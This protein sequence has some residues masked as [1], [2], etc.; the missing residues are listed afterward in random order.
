[1]KSVQKYTETFNWSDNFI[2]PFEDQCIQVNA[3]C[4]WSAST[5]QCFSWCSE[6]FLL[7]FPTKN[8]E[9]DACR[10]NYFIHCMWIFGWLVAVCKPFYVK[11]ESDWF[12]INQIGDNCHTWSMMSVCYSIYYV[13]GSRQLK[14]IK[15][16][17][18]TKHDMS[19]TYKTPIPPPLSTTRYSKC[20]YVYKYEVHHIS[21]CAIYI[22]C[23][24][25]LS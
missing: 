18:H 21:F 9:G 1:M 2:F 3:L 25:Y 12:D 20:I 7:Y 22:I 11:V 10:V 13:V 6:N 4:L 5:F 8:Y 16:S 19:R 23:F 14:L 15:R 17:Q 24:W